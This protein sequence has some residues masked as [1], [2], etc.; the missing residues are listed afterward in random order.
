MGKAIRWTITVSEET[1]LDLR[2]FLGNRGMKK[3]DLSRFVEEAVRWRVF[4]QTVEAIRK[5][6]EDVSTDEL[7]SLIDTA[8]QEVRTARRER[9]SGMAD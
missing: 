6:N 3:G 7:N 5:D 8:L 9:G 1:D 2:R 4:D